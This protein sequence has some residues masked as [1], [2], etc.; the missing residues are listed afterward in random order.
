[1]K[2]NFFESLALVLKNEGGFVDHPDDP[3]GATNRGI[4]LKTFRSAYGQDATV[5]DLKKI[6]D[7]QVLTIYK[8]MY[9]NKCRCSD[10]PAGVDLCVFDAAV[11][12]G[13]H[14]SGIWLQR[15]VN[16]KVDGLIGPQTIRLAWKENPTVIIM[17]MMYARLIHL[18]VLS[19]WD[20][21]SHGW[22]R[23]IK[24]ICANALKMVIER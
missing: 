1:M 19:T 5:E 3:G 11:H 13:P 12:S 7:N 21:F 8:E 23:R 18:R 22:T 6:T 4:T 10:L 17:K 24:H 9:W 16:A 15:A 14:T 20:V 2:N